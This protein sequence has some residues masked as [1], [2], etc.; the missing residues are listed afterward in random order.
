MAITLTPNHDETNW[1]PDRQ[2]HP[3]YLIASEAAE[4][5]ASEEGAGNEEQ[6]AARASSASIAFTLRLPTL[7]LPGR[8]DLATACENALVEKLPW[9]TSA[10]AIAKSRRPRYHRGLKGQPR[11]STPTSISGSG[12]SPTLSPG[13][14]AVGNVVCVSSCKGGVGKSTVAVNL[15]YS[16]AA[17]GA[18]VGLLDADI[19]GPSL[20]TLVNVSMPHVHFSRE[21]PLLVCLF[22]T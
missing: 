10:T 12:A 18:K 3:H 7:A 19:Y 14:E 21:L 15:A 6:R 9:V 1:H 2:R 5:D 13:L 16:L 22:Q 8:H 17:R 4:G 20:P 11:S